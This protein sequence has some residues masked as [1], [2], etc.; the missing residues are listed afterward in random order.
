MNTEEIKNLIKRHEGYRDRVY[1]DSVGVPTSGYGHAHLEGSKITRQIADLHFKDDFQGAVKDYNIL[2]A[3]NNLKLDPVRRAVL[4][5]MLFNMGLVKVSGFRNTLR[6]IRNGEYKRAAKHLLDS[7]YA[8][9]VGPRAIRLA[10]M[11]ETGEYDG[12]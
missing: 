12:L 11:M 8:R 3:N 5:D 4:I 6:H 10:K 7:K 2:A 1:I 9:Q